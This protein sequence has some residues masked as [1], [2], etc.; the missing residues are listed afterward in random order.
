M[1]SQK[2]TEKT[3]NIRVPI[4]LHQKIKVHIAEQGITLKDYMLQLIENDLKKSA[5]NSLSGWK[6]PKLKGV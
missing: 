1:T 6:P 2:P 4:E 3:I 5:K